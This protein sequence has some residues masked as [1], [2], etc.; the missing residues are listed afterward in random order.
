MNFKKLKNLISEMQAMEPPHYDRADFLKAKIMK[1]IDSEQVVANQIRNSMEDIQI[2]PNMKARIKI[3]LME[4]IEPKRSFFPKFVS[5]VAS[6]TLLMFV[7]VYLYFFDSVVFLR[8]D[9]Y[10][11][12]LTEVSGQVYVIRG[13]ETLEGYPNMLLQESDIV[14]TGNLSTAAIKYVD[15]SV[16]RLN[17]DSSV[18]L[19]KL[20]SH[21]KKKTF[22]V[23]EVELI[24]GDI[25]NRVVNIVE[26]DGSEFRVKAKN[27]STQASRKA[28]FNVKTKPDGEVK[29]KVVQ[30]VVDVK[31]EKK[32][33][34]KLAEGYQAVVSKDIVVE[35]SV[36]N[37]EEE[38]QWIAANLEKDESYIKEI[39]ETKKE[40]RK[41]MVGALPDSVLYPI[42]EIKGD[43][44]LLLTLDETK[45]EE[46]KF[47]VAY[48]RLQEAQVLVDLGNVDDAQPIIEEFKGN[49]D[50][51]SGYIDSLEDKDPERALDLKIKL[52]DAIDGTIKDL[53]PIGDDDPLY[54]VKETLIET[55]SKIEAAALELEQEDV[56]DSVVDEE[57]AVVE[58][59]PEDVV[60][61]E[62][63]ESVEFELEGDNGGV[64]GIGLED[65]PLAPYFVES[66]PAAPVNQ[67]RDQIEAKIESSV[68]TVTPYVF[69]ENG[70]NIVVPNGDDLVDETLEVTPP[71]V[72]DARGTELD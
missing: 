58:V 1:S 69:E 65:V 13:G 14:S 51:F 40:E 36:D 42:K 62:A 21:S 48:R 19:S 32:G 38:K 37:D 61:V 68:E 11:T 54:I 23:V 47:D 26:D 60:D 7:G 17:G 50:D 27:V 64:D 9:V 45:K 24:Q 4:Q 52:N 44:K 10:A 33:S 6:G 20:F 29:V 25:W 2:D 46:L 5:F 30:S 70:Q 18:K 53:E 15:E 28:A 49:V 59:Q 71:S 63:I 55:E 41:K 3:R 12:V 67:Y 31:D 66:H 22:T 39:V 43:T 72:F 57:I 16:S 56:V 8:N 34:K 35:Q